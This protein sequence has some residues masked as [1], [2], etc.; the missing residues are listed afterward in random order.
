MPVNTSEKWVVWKENQVNHKMVDF[1]GVYDSA[2]E[3][4]DQLSSLRK[5]NPPE[6]GF[7]YTRDLLTH[8]E[9]IFGPKARL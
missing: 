6:P 2:Q 3:A 9:E 1:I 5:N 4:C 7:E 8:Y